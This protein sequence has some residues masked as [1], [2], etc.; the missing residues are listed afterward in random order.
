MRRLLVILLLISGL[1]VPLG[2]QQ[3]PEAPLPPE[4]VARGAADVAHEIAHPEEA[5]QHEDRRYFGIPGGILKFVNMVLF[6][7]LLGWLL[8]G[9]IGRFFA[10]RKESIRTR[11][12]DAEARREKADRMAEEIR[13]RLARVEAELEAIRSRADEEGARQHAQ[14]VDSSNRE[15]EKILTAARGEIDQRMKQARRELRHFAAELATERASGIVEGSIG[16]ADRRKIFD[17][18]VAR[19]REVKG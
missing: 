7:G 9:P 19:I 17:E 2:A 18:S 1:V 8:K 14:I 3:E 5:A 13:G 4:A 11:L 16:E 10:S 6:I 12:A 15:A